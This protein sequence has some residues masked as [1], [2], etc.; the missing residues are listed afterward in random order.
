MRGE[1]SRVVNIVVSGSYC[2]SLC[3]L[4]VT[5]PPAGSGS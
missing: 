4:G 3:T 5:S 2:A 1:R